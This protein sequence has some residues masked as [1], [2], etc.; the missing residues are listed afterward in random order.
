MDSLI[1]IKWS[2]RNSFQKEGMLAIPERETHTQTHTET[3]MGAR[4][5]ER[6]R[7]RSR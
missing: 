5:R 4:G 2:E 6:E 1:R 7:F 3:E